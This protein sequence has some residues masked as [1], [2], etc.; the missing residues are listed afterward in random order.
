[1]DILIALFKNGDNSQRTKVNSWLNSHTRDKFSITLKD[2]FFLQ[3]LDQR[4]GRNTQ[5]YWSISFNQSHSD[6][7]NQFIDFTNEW[8]GLTLRSLPEL[9]LAQLLY[10]HHIPFLS[11]T[12]GLVLPLPN[13][14][15]DTLLSGRVEYDFILLK[16]LLRIE[17]DGQHHLNPQQRQLDISG[18]R[19]LQSLNIPT[20]RFNATDILK[21]PQ[22]VINEIL[23]FCHL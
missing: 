12:K 3:Y 6:K 13:T 4:D 15:S 18:D 16:P 7:I 20:L 17:L 21:N 2:D 5:H 14:L 19:L 23:S 8:Q 10:E 22:L 1:M 11:N 9:K